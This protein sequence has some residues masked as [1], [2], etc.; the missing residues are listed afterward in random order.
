[1]KKNLEKISNNCKAFAGR[2]ALK[3]A[4]AATL[5]MAAVQTAMCDGNG[6]SEITSLVKSIIDVIV[7]IFPFVGAFFIVSGVFKLIQAY[8]TDQPENQA[9]AAKDIVIGAVFVVFKAFVWDQISKG[10][11]GQA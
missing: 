6:K 11:F 1:M 10:V 7:Q 9:S 2:T 8:R 5:V 4:T 3:T